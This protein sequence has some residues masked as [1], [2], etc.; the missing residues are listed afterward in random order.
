MVE[1][2][3]PVGTHTNTRQTSFAVETI[4][5]DEQER[6]VSIL[7]FWHK[8]E[9]FIPFDL[10]QRIAEADEHK[11]RYLHRQDLNRGS[12]TLW[13]VAVQEDEEV[14]LFRLYLGVFDKSEITNVCD[15]I[16]GPSEDTSDEE[17]ERTGLEGRTCFAQ[18]TI[19]P[20]GELVLESAAR[21]GPVSFISTLPWALGQF[22]KAGFASLTF[23]RFENAKQDLAGLL[24]NFKAT[25]RLRTGH[26]SGECVKPLTHFEILELHEIFQNWAGFSVPEAGLIGVLEIVTGKRKKEDTAAEQPEKANESD[27]ANEDPEVNIAILNSFFIQ[28]IESA[29]NAI[30]SG[31]IGG[32]LKH[33][34]SPLPTADRVDLESAPGS[35]GHSRHVASG[36]SE[37]RPLV[38]ECRPV[39]DINATIC[40]QLNG[41]EFSRPSLVV[42]RQRAARNGENNASPRHLR[43]SD[44][45]PR[46]TPRQ[47]ESTVGCISPGQ[48]RGFV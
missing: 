46:A 21:S 35:R 3:S 47:I 12:L 41:A 24:L 19:D 30:K 40:H 1:V 10:D 36:S 33:F 5:T 7:S 44:C 31:Q 23:D 42:L 32:A 20:T 17:F 15:Q 16:L 43:G 38:V 8:I 25:R 13:E 2:E 6:F 39:Y 14:K 37:S 11:I 22:E 4:S 9:F 18:L 26:E 28:D 29:I 45:A 34:L 48:I 27:S